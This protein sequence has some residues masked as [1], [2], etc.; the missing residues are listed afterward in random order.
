ML[1]VQKYL[2]TKTLDD[3][4][5]ELGIEINKHREHPLAILNYN[6]IE[7]PKT[8]PIVRECRA[9]TLDTRSNALVSRSFNRFFNVGEVVDEMKLFN[10]SNSWASSKEDGSLLK[11]FNFEN[12]W[13][14]CTR[15]SW[16]VDIMPG[17]TSLTW[18]DVIETAVGKIEELKL[19]PA[20]T[21]ICELCSPYNKVVRRYAE[22]KVYLL[23]MFKGEQEL[24]QDLV[25]YLKPEKML[26]PKVHY[27]GHIDDVTKHIQ[28]VSAVDSSY[29][30]IVLCDDG[31][32]RWKVK[33]PTYLAL[34]AMWGNGNLFLPKYLLPFILSG[35]TSELL[36]YYKEVEATLEYYQNKV[37][38]WKRELDALW[39]TVKGEENQKSYALRVKDHCL[40]ALM[41]QARKEKSKPSELF[42]KNEQ[43][44][45]KYL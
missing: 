6:Q 40:S 35:E 18:R 19:D 30:G 15:G 37:N 1:E 8:H 42:I 13:F 11:F 33:S 28:D 17:H 5:A 14:A 7:S 29:E 20:L 21:Y 9:L 10:W 31:F 24:G 12:K 39:E 45:L 34:H 26:R 3:L 2:E 32:R 16:G 41:F 4:H 27:F 38:A 36:V 22:P 25:N 44:L 23:T 43:L